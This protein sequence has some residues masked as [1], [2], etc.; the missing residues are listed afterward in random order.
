MNVKVENQEKNMA[1]ITVEVEYAQ[2]ADAC[3]KAYQKNK[4]KIS[5]PGFRKGK[6]PKKMIEKMYGPQI[7]WE[8][9]IDIVLDA[10]Y[11]EAAKESGLE[12]VSRPEINVEKIEIDKPVVYTA[13]VAVKPEVK[14]GQYKGVKAVKVSSEVTDEEVE[15]RLKRVQDQNARLVTVE[16]KDREIAK[17]DIVSIDFEGF[18]DGKTFAGGKGDNYPLTI[19]SHQFI[20]TFEDQCIGHKVG[21]EFEVNVT[22]PTGY[23]SKDLAGK[24]AM[25]KVK[26]NEIKVRELPELDDEFAS[27][28]SEF[29][30]LDEFKADL[31]K[32]LIEEKEKRAAQ[33]NENNVVK[34][35]VEGAE[36]DVPGPMV[37]NQVDRMLNDYAARLQSQG[38]PLDQ[39]LS[40]TGMTVENIREQMKPQALTTIK[41]RLVL[42]AVVAAEKIEATEDDFNAEVEKMAENYKME[43]DKL[44]EMIGENEKKAMMLDLACQKAID[45]LV[46]EAVLEEAKEEKKEEADK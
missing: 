36:I 41:T 42:E 21:D 45:M 19:G 34:A 40:I 22:F 15:A 28:V 33:E 46:A 35:V 43:A 32:Q 23:H 2:F 7:F 13:T 29:E 38:I 30:K 9:A 39:Y 3:E 16:D 44:K 4:S 5:I 12:I 10:T 1:K 27:E 26:V 20:D 24:P 11:P 31:K 37:D 6:A 17:N 14:L 18:I 8:D 25:F